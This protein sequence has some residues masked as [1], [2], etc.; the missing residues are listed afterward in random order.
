[1]EIP[2]RGIPPYV[3]WS[4]GFTGCP[5]GHPSGSSTYREAITN[6]YTI[7]F[8]GRLGFCDGDLQPAR[9]VD[10]KNRTVFSMNNQGEVDLLKT[11]GQ[12]GVVYLSV[13]EE[14]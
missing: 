14:G 13:T 7:T 2:Q 10:G 9:V 6:M 11:I 5:E 4:A 3:V 1:M 12:T 8:S